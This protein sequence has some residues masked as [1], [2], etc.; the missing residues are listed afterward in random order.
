MTEEQKT[1]LIERYLKKELPDA[2]RLDVERLIENDAQFAEEVSVMRLMLDTLEDKELTQFHRDVTAAWDAEKEDEEDDN[3]EKQE[4]QLNTPPEPGAM[5]AGWSRRRWLL[6]A[7]LAIAVAAAGIWQYYQNQPPA[8]IVNKP[9][10]PGQEEPIPP[11]PP[12]TARTAPPVR[13]QAQNQRQPNRQFIA[14]AKTH[15]GNA[16]EFANI[17]KAGGNAPVDSLTR[18]QQ[19]ERAFADKQ[20]EKAVRLLAEPDAKVQESALY[21]RGHAHFNAGHY[22]AA[23]RDFQSVAQMAGYNLDDATWYLLLSDLALYGP[24]NETVRKQL[25]VIADDSGHPFN[26]EAKKLRDNINR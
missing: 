9:D 3:D 15:Y 5:Q 12:D 17:R 2:E 26:A 25:Q 21:L 7:A 19:A 22:E 6:A 24:A 13:P 10:T 23:A 14:M 1:L 20:F 16:P 11:L 8:P 18:L 4:P